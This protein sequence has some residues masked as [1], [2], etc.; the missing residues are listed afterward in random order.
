MDKSYYIM[1]HTYLPISLKALYWCATTMSMVQC[2]MTSGMT[3][4]LQSSV[5]S[6]DSQRKVSC[7]VYDPFLYLMQF[8]CEF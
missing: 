3:L 2:V 7:F 1:G 4:R 5:A 6:L 8:F